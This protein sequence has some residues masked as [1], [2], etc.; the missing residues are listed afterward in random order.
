MCSRAFHQPIAF[1]TKALFF[2]AWLISWPAI[3]IQASPENI[4]RDASLNKSDPNSDTTAL[5]YSSA[6]AMDNQLTS[7]S[8]P[9]KARPRQA[10]SSKQSAKR[11][12]SDKQHEVMRL[13]LMDVPKI[14]F[15]SCLFLSFACLFRRLARRTARQLQ[16]SVGQRFRAVKSAK[17]SG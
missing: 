13:A 6:N 4:L 10:I 14:A 17:L 15:V 8:L 5:L 3:A 2:S 12:L 16:C 9:A 11:L 7:I 1:G